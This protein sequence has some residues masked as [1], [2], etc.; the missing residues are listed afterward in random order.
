MI[1]NHTYKRHNQITE[2]PYACT[3]QIT[4]IQQYK[5]TIFKPWQYY[6]DATIA[7]NI[8]HREIIPI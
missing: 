7:L 2:R 3:K 6:N 4:L 5:I 1:R 8:L